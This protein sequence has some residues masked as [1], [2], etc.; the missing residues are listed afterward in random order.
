MK[1]AKTI[2][3]ADPCILCAKGPRGRISKME[4]KE[5]APYTV[6]IQYPISESN[7]G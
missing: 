7:Q 5:I 4:S 1:T 3:V 2:Q 6:F